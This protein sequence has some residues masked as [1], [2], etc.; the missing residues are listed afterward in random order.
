MANLRHITIDWTYPRFLSEYNSHPSKDEF[1]VYYI[2]RCIYY[3]DHTD[4]TPVYIGKTRQ[5]FKDRMYQLGKVVWIYSS[6][7]NLYG[8]SVILLFS[9][10][11]TKILG[12][13]PV[14]EQKVE[15]DRQYC[16]P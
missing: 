13:P 1:G 8:F 15:P 12:F 3:A 9:C 4:E 7:H 16:W 11:L 10:K 5:P 14:V 6:F 2:S